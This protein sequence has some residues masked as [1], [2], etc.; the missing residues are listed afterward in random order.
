MAYSEDDRGLSRNLSWNL[1]V[2]LKVRWVGAEVCD[3]SEGAID[4]GHC[5]ADEE[6]AGEAHVDGGLPEF[7]VV[8]I[9]QT[10]RLA[11]YLSFLRAE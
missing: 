5:S 1:N 10:S 7:G 8:C 9:P 11:R 6:R 4:S 3:A 2:H